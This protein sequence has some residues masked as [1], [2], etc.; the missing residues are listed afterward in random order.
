MGRWGEASPPTCPPKGCRRR[1]RDERR[2]TGDGSPYRTL[3]GFA[4]FAVWTWL[5]P[6]LGALVAALLAGAPAPARAAAPAAAPNLVFIFADD[7]GWGDL[8]SHG[9]PYL[10][11]PHLDRLAAQGTDFR[12]FTVAGSV[13]S[14]SRAAIMTGQFPARFNIHGH[15]AT[16]ES[17][18]Q[19]GMPDWLNPKTVLLPR[20]LQQAG[21]A[22]AHFGKWHLTN[23][24][25]PDAPL[26]LNYGYDVAGTFNGPGPQMPVHDD[27]KNSIAFIE[28]S[29]AA[30]KPFFLNLWI[31]EP[32]T[33]HYPKPEYLEKF[34]HLPDEA[35]RVYAAVIAHADARIG[36]LLAALDRLGLA[37]DTLV[38]FSSDNGP[39]ITGPAGRRMTEDESTGPG[40]GTWASVGSTGGHRGHKRSLLQGGIGVP[41]LARW[42][43]K[44]A[45]GRIDDTT[46]L[47]A[48]DLLPTFCAL[49]GA[50]LP[51]AYAPDGLD[52]TAALLGQAAAART[53]P[54]FWQWTTAAKTGD[55]WPAL[56]VRD[57]GGKL[58]VG[59]NPEQVELFRFPSD[60]FEK[61]N[62]SQEQA[63]EVSRLRSLLAAW[64]ATLPAKPDPACFSATRTK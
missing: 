33:P 24:M 61:S 56:A 19:R 16:V 28:R 57:G 45:A 8:G 47:T 40:L 50:K 18:V 11:T 62:L 14:P 27:V 53:K 35:Q 4:K 29:Q 60:S 39:E 59:N 15:F 64:T 54:I 41:F 25:V 23:I 10:K 17:H 5:R 55:N 49:A 2:L 42:P 48:V 1:S 7:W 3:T 36:E 13:C 20:L 32:H 43:G 26:P 6:R 63:P 9:H 58:L 38:I 31:H 34:A 30:G 21:Y 46:P 51:P 52:Q 22:T 12:Q 37:R 44:I